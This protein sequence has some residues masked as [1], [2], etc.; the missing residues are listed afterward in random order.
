MRHI[1]L[2]SPGNFSSLKILREF[3]AIFLINL[4]DCLARQILSGL[5]LQKSKCILI[6]I[7]IKLLKPLSFQ[8]L[9]KF[10]VS[11]AKLGFDPDGLQANGRQVIFRISLFIKKNIRRQLKFIFLVF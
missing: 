7:Q 5:P 1:L 2:I 9:F 11:L 4:P 10:V 8:Q 3:I 6:K